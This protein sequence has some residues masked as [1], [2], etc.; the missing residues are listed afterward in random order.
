MYG[1]DVVVRRRRSVEEEIVGGGVVVF[2]S[3]LVPP[4]LELEVLRYCHNF[5]TNLKSLLVRSVS[6]VLVLCVSFFVAESEEWKWW[7][8]NVSV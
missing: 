4:L 1:E 2:I 5:L 6:C 7:Y 3:L 8:V